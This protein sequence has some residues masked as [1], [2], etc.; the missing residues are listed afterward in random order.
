M[1]VS[2]WQCPINPAFGVRPERCEKKTLWEWGCSNAKSI[3]LHTLQ[4]GLFGFEMVLV[5]MRFGS[6]PIL[7]VR[8]R[9]EF[10][11]F[12]SGWANDFVMAAC[13]NGGVIVTRGRNN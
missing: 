11:C 6:F 7:I 2:I 13:R 3:E 5:G 9:C 4:T 8:H 10:F 12:L 1:R